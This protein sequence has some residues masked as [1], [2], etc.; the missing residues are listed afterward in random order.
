MNS[1]S[2]FAP[3]FAMIAL[4]LVVWIYMDARRIPFIMRSNLTPEQLSPL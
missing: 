4:T 2:I 3:F 1:M